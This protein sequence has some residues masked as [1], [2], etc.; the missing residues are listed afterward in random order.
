[1]V[2][3]FVWGMPNGRTIIFPKSGRGPASRSINGERDAWRTLFSLSAQVQT[4]GL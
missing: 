2:H 4:C 1:L 3:G